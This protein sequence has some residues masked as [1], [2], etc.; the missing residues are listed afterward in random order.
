ML[1]YLVI[2]VVVLA[3]VAYLVRSFVMTARGRSGGCGAGCGCGSP[4]K[5]EPNLGK[6]HDLISL[7]VDST[8]TPE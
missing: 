4:L 2:G 6:R 7:K 3:A 1:E 8:H 5:R